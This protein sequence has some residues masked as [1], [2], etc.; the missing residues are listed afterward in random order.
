MQYDFLQFKNATV[1]V[2]PDEFILT[3]VDREISY[4]VRY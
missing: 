1:S 2:K 4:K 3:L